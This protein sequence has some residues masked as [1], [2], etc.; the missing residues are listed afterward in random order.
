MTYAQ[1]ER[2][3]ETEL[4]KL[5]DAGEA[6]TITDW[7]VE[8]LTRLNRIQR[9]Q[10]QATIIPQDTYL[11]LQAAQEQ[12][13]Q[14][15]PVQ[16]VLCFAPFLGMKFF[17]NE[18]VLIPRPET[19]ELV[20]W[21]V[22]SYK[23]NTQPLQILDI[24][25]GSGCIAVS[26][27]RK[28]PTAIVHAIDLSPDALQIAK[29]NATGNDTKVHFQLLDFLDESS[30]QQLAQYHIIVSNPPYIPAQDKQTMDEN[31]TAW[32]PG[33]ALFV[34]DEDPLLFYKKIAAFSKTHLLEGGVVFLETH[35]QYAGAVQELFTASGYT[36]AI[37]KDMYGN[38]RMVMATKNE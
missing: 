32:E 28:L 1:F 22:D 38:E 37:K 35:Q 23:N 17:V 7:V 24:G 21:M 20:H 6:A 10:M 26:L 4:Q 11:T 16:Y 13:L 31:V 29:N 3:L 15:K 25:T 2:T 12:L 18:S 14:H 36:A 19:E 30:W 9:R 34:P 27:K 33:V 8:E 5:Y